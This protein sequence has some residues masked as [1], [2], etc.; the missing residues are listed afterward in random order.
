MTICGPLGILWA[1]LIPRLLGT[2]RSSNYV[3]DIEYKY[4]VYDTTNALKA[5]ALRKASQKAETSEYECAD[6]QLPIWSMVNYT[7]KH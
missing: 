6:V 2:L 5:Q 1:R 3:L 4:N 7:K